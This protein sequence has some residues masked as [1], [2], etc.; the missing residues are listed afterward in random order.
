MVKIVNTYT[1]QSASHSLE[2]SQP[3]PVNRTERQVSGTEHNEL[4]LLLTF[5]S[6]SGGRSGTGRSGAAS[7]RL[8]G[9]RFGR[10]AAVDRLAF[11]A[12][13]YHHRVEARSGRVESRRCRRRRLR[14]LRRSRVKRL[15]LFVVD[16]HAL[17]LLYGLRR[18]LLRLLS[19]SS[20]AASWWS[21]VV[22]HH[23]IVEAFF[24]VVACVYAASFSLIGFINTFLIEIWKIL[25][26]LNITIDYK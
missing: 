5:T 14:R 22:R 6:S 26:A 15:G 3:P 17:L 18:L 1:R 8:R 16:S 9:W 2:S 20:A 24:I 12:A 19:S 25:E 13:C 4:M 21:A 23:Y 10:V 11:I 7:T